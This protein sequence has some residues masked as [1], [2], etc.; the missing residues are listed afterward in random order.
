MADGEMRSRRSTWLREAP[1]ATCRPT[2]RRCISANPSLPTCEDAADCDLGRGGLC[3]IGRF[4][5]GPNTDDG[6][7]RLM[8]ALRLP[9]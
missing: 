9:R 4:T 1:L 2:P 3:M 7:A 5:I 6:R 8:F